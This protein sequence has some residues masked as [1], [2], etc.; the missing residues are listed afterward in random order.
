MGRYYPVYCRLAESKDV[1]PWA[2]TIELK[3]DNI[4]RRAMDFKM[5]IFNRCYIRWWYL[6]L[7]R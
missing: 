6:A 5:W 3:D 1:K 2:Y 7:E 4:Y